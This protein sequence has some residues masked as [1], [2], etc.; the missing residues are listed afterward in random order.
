MT[1]L[2]FEKKKRVLTSLYMVYCRVGLPLVF[3]NLMN[4]NLYKSKVLETSSTI[5]LILVRNTLCNHS[6]IMHGCSQCLRM[7]CGWM[8]LLHNHVSVSQCNTS[9]VSRGQLAIGLPRSW[10][11]GMK[12]LSTSTK[13]EGFFPPNWFF[14]VIIEKHSKRGA[15]NALKVTPSTRD[16]RLPSWLCSSLPGSSAK[17]QS[18][19]VSLSCSA[20][21]AA[22][23]GI[24]IR[25]LSNQTTLLRVGT[26]Q[27]LLYVNTLRAL[28]SPSAPLL[29]LS[30]F[31]F[32]AIQ[33]LI[34]HFVVLINSGMPCVALSL[35]CVIC[36]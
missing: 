22:V 17:W 19:A 28:R 15:K 8:E 20:S 1:R 31:S 7:K 10:F 33:F 3:L 14:L 34:V 26:L 32:G 35:L 24:P 13:H 29:C 2:F 5:L 18:C 6:D 23:A 25:S 12:E 27:I 9:M 16:K 36:F 30:R 21:S 4:G 11:D